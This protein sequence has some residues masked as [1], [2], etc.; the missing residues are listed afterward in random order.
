MR[1]V[2][3]AQMVTLDSLFAGPNGEIDWHTVDDEFFK[4]TSHQLASMDAILFGRV[5]YQ[6]M[7]SYW[8]T[9]EAISS[10]PVT[11][12]LMNDTPKVVFSKTLNKVEWQNSRLVKT[13]LVEE[14]KRL[15]QQ[16]GKDILIFGSGQI[17][18]A[19]TPHGLIDLYRLFI[20]PLVLGRGMP[21][22]T[23]ITTPVKFKL[24]EATPYNNG[25]VQLDY[26]PAGG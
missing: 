13:D 25:L 15:K 2:I 10:D 16:P 11:A 14:V 4:A 26:A 3:L 19:L 12:K 22:F 1:K 6:V 5:T 17:V 21:L 7:S 8:P 18:S 23:G 24:L 9:P 20:N